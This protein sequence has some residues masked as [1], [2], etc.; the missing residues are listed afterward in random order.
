MQKGESDRSL[1]VNVG[2]ELRFAPEVD[3]LAVIQV[4]PR[5]DGRQQVREDTFEADPPG[6]MRLYDDVFDNVCRR[7]AMPSGDVGFRYNAVVEVSAEPDE[8]EPGARELLP[9]D[10]PD[11]CLLFTQPSRYC[12]SDVL[13]D[14]AW[15][16]FGNLEPGWGRVQAICDWVHTNIRYEIGSTPMTTAVDV[17]QGRT[18]VCRDFAHLAVSFC[19]S[20]NIPARYVFG[21]LPDVQGTPVDEP[22][23]FA[24]WFE[25]YLGDRWWTFDARN[26]V[27]L[28][29]RVVVGRGRDALDVAM[30][31]TYSHVP[32]TGFRVWANELR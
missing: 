32:L 2:C 10:L 3:T 14:P 28:R 9:V 21:Y 4:Q 15:E 19:R 23:D 27:R 31:T 11:E 30:V 25:A 5:S 12:L 26:N 13:G 7:W 22:M 29:G 8:L 6:Q 20:L 24:A 18:G 17:Y 1:K 16:M